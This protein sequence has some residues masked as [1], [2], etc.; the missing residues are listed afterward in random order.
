V[1]T[2]AIDPGQQGL[3]WV[4]GGE[5]L[6]SGGVVTLGKGKLYTEASVATGA[7]PSPS[8]VRHIALERMWYYPQRSSAKASSEIK[9]IL[10]LQAIGGLVAGYY[11]VPITYYTAR[12]WMGGSLPAHIVQG[13]VEMFLQGQEKDVFASILRATRKDL[14][15]NAYDA[16][17][18]WL[19][20][21]GR[22]K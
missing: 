9:A 3:A 16:A 10:D 1:T 6:I 20:H 12:E 21:Q 11:R 13:R 17:G 22:W 2:L 7:M 18:I 8:Q 14:R 5:E 19:R 15:H 4:L